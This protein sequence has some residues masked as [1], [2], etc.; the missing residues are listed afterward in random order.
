MAGDE[1]L[2]ALLPDPP[3]PRPDRRETAIGA[4]LRR[5]DGIEEPA[6]TQ[7]PAAAQRP[8][9]KRPSRGQLGA[10]AS[11]ALVAAIG[12]PVALVSIGQFAPPAERPVPPPAADR[13]GGAA[14]RAPA[15]PPKTAAP[16]SVPAPAPL[17]A[18]S[19]AA[20]PVIA[21]PAAPPL[22]EAMP[23]PHRHHRHHR[24]NP[25]RRPRR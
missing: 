16:A 9:W 3:P 18:P 8:S 25:R 13:A 10:F 15:S 21:R 11:I 4:A 19:A 6:P 23:N 7:G 12:L 14:D 5:F 17:V 20:S 22:V 1:D 2:A 24:P